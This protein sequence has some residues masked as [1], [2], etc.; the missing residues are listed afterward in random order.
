M[1]SM[2]LRALNAIDHRLTKPKHPWTN[3]QIERMNHTM[4]GAIVKRYF[5]HSPS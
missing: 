5:A 1:P 3:D 4:K 2:C